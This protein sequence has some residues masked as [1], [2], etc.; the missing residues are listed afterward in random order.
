M[1]VLE[2]IGATYDPYPPRRERAQ[3]LGRRY[4]FVSELLAFYGRLSEVQGRAFIAAQEWKPAPADLPDFVVSRVLPE[5]VDVTTAAGPRPLV[6][7]VV[8]CFVQADLRA[9]VASWL[10]GADQPAVEAYLARAATQPVVESLGYTLTPTLPRQGGGRTCPRCGGL[11]QLSYF[12]VSGEALVS[13]PRYLVCAR[14]SYAW[15]F[16]RMTCAGCGE[17]DTLRL[18]IY[19]EGE[20]LPHLRVDAC[21]RCHR[22]LLTV[23][24]RQDGQAVPIVDELAALPLDL[25]ARERG[26]TKITPNLLGN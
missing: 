16:S 26:M 3:A 24:L 6:D 5:V 12:A 9:M 10:W 23:D 4:A 17:Q 14:C 20:V 2:A 18:P 19:Q 7:G 1:Q 8:A 21:E 15:I 13:G 11:P 25:Y 22:Y